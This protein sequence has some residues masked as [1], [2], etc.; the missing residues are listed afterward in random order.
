VPAF[1]NVAA[2]AQ[3]LVEADMGARTM[4]VAFGDEERLREVVLELAGAF[5]HQS[6]AGCFRRIAVAPRCRRKHPTHLLRDHSVLLGDRPVSI[7]RER[8]VRRSTAGQIFALATSRARWI[9]TSAVAK[10]DKR[11]AEHGSSWPRRKN[12]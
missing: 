8:D 11:S 12:V 9:S 4:R 5:D 7:S 10:S 6:V 1:Q 2:G 3:R